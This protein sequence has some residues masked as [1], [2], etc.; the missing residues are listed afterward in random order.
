MK[1]AFGIHSAVSDAQVPYINVDVLL[2]A[3]FTQI[4]AHLAKDGFELGNIATPTPA[5]QNSAAPR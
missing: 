5:G 1:N 3:D 2:P 4:K